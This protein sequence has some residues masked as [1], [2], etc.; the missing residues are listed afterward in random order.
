MPRVLDLE[1]N[2]ADKK[3]WRS[4]R[5]IGSADAP[6]ILGVDPWTTQFQC[7]SLK[8]YRTQRTPTNFAQQRGIDLEPEARREAEWE[9]GSDYKPANLVHD[10]YRFIR[11][12]LDGWS[13]DRRSLLEIKVPGKE[14]HQQALDGIIPLNYIP[15][16]DHLL[17]VS[18]SEEAIYYSYE[19]GMGGVSIRYGRDEKKLKKLLKLELAFWQ[20]IVN[21]QPPPLTD[22]DYIYREDPDWSKAAA[23]FAKLDAILKDT[24]TTY[25]AAKQRLI[26]LANGHSS[27]GS[28]VK[29]CAYDRKKNISWKKAAEDLADI[30]GEKVDWEKYREDGKTRVNEIEVL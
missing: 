7:W 3:E 2:D 8:T 30:M 24:K 13:P 17:M 4:I 12:A 14:K 28:G 22:K 10:K 21:D 18:G 29:L 9:F 26:D 25:E 16:L 5:G 19:P 15:Q 11:A 20:Y 27:F 23:E 6:I 1:H